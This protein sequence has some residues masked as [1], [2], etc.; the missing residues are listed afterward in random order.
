M[1]TVKCINQWKIYADSSNGFGGNLQTRYIGKIHVR[2]ES[3]KVSFTPSMF[4]VLI[5]ES[6][7][8]YIHEQMQNY[9]KE[10][11]KC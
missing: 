11:L 9:K 8:K 6:T 2:L 1:N 4:T 5:R 7:L 3:G 10:Q